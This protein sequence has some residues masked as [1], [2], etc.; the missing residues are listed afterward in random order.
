MSIAKQ[1]LQDR[2]ENVRK[3]AVNIL[4]LLIVLTSDKDKYAQIL[5]LSL[6][7]LNDEST[8]VANAVKCVLCPVLAQWSFSLKTIQSDLFSKLLN[9]LKNNRS[10]CVINVIETLLPFLVMSVADSEFI[11]KD[12]SRNFPPAGKSK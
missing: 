10:M 4:A 5:D 9:K 8:V 6:Q 7:I 2:E 12:L 3:E 1:L 11:T